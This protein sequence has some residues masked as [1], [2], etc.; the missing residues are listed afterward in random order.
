VP[1]REGQINWRFYIA[2]LVVAALIVVFIAI[3]A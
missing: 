2:V 3:F 1:R